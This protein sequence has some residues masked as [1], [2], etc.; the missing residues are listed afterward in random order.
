[1]S[2]NR[3]LA[4]LC[5]RTGGSRRTRKE[6]RAKRNV[7][8]VHLIH[9]KAIIFG[10]PLSL[11]LFFI[12]VTSGGWSSHLLWN[13]KERHSFRIPVFNVRITWGGQVWKS[14]TWRTVYSFSQP[15][16]CWTTEE[17]C[18]GLKSLFLFILQQLPWEPYSN[19]FFCSKPSI[20]NP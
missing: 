1:M 6:C 10:H 17:I 13:T 11:D 3:L 12:S 20:L 18:K 19:M 16:N 7:L 4:V 14:N 15:Q 2:V 8:P 5:G 9:I